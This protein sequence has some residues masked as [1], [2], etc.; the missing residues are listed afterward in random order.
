MSVQHE[1]SVKTGETGQ[2]SIAV[3]GDVDA[4]NADEVRFAILD[5]AGRSGGKLEV[6]LS[7]L[8][9]MDSS[10]LRA[11]ADAAQESEALGSRLTLRNVPDR[12]L[13]LAAISDIWAHLEVI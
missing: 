4:S 3:A 9:F 13:R 5:A 11:I 2:A 7:G 1:M 12:V 10:G 6:D 8:T